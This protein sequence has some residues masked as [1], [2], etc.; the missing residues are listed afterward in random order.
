MSKSRDIADSAATINYIDG[1][2]SDAQGQLDDKAT[3]DG[4]PTFTGTVTATAFSGDGSGLT[5][6]DSLPS[7]TGNTG[8]FLTTDGSAASWD[9]VDISSE[10]TG[11]LPVA[12]GGTGATTLAANN[13]L[14]G[15]G[16]SSPLAVAPSTAGNVLTSNGTTWQSVA[17][18]GGGAWEL[19]G[20]IT[21][22]NSASVVFNNLNS[23]Y[24]SY[25]FVFEEVSLDHG[26]QLYMLTSEDNGSTYYEGGDH[27]NKAIAYRSGSAVAVYTAETNRYQVT[28][29]DPGSSSSSYAPISGT[30]HVYNVGRNTRFFSAITNL[31]YS[32]TSQ[33]HL[34]Y[35]GSC[36]SQSVRNVNAI[37]FESQLGNLNSGRISLYGVKNS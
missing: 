34:V 6:V 22:S 19:I 3:L 8:K 18:A 7:Q 35:V 15:N 30:A 29:V 32:D 20:S 25:V 16:T 24:S 12:N 31:T 10:I 13:V 33:N 27:R 36:Y 9:A 17:P 1:L 5:G 23:S 14:L 37:K 21:L 26:R 4:S 2:T 11:T 28:M